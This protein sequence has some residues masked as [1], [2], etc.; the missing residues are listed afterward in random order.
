MEPQMP[1][2]QIVKATTKMCIEFQE[3]SAS[4]Y[5]EARL[6]IDGRD[7]YAPRVIATQK[8]AAMYAEEARVRL[9]RLIGIA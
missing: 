7:K 5:A 8:K 4:A 2:N 6:W 3:A 1:D 9:E